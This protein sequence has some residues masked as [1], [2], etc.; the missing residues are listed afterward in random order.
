[1]GA[2]FFQPCERQTSSTGDFQY[3]LFYQMPIPD[4]FSGNKRLFQLNGST[5]LAA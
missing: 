3:L 4:E 5:L 1:M 2:V